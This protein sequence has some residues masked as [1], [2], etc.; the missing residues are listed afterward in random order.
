ML[1]NNASP[2]CSRMLKQKKEG[3]TIGLEGQICN[4]DLGSRL[5]Y[6]PAQPIK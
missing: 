1:G 3:D 5:Q 4:A 6:F 2:T